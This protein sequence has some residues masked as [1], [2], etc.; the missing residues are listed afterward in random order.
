LYKFNDPI[1]LIDEILIKK[2]TIPVNTK[3]LF[4]K[5]FD[6]GNCQ[7]EINYDNKTYSTVVTPKEIKLDEDIMKINIRKNKAKA[8]KYL[9]IIA[10]KSLKGKPGKVTGVGTDGNIAVRTNDMKEDE[11]SIYFEPND[12]KIIKR[13]Y[14]NTYI[15]FIREGFQKVI[16]RKIYMKEFPV[17]LYNDFVII[18]R[19]GFED[20]LCDARYYSFL[21]D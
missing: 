11:V 15:P 19:S 9:D 17:L 14:G 4:V 8:F 18:E 21:Q 7:I 5:E 16:Y 6:D 3:G 12:L 10:I 1:I 2:I 20:L 13:K